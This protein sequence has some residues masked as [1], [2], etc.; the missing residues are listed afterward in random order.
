[1]TEKLGDESGVGSWCG[2]TC[3]VAQFGFDDCREKG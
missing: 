1:M 2:E 3:L